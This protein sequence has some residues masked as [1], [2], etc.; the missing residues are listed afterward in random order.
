[1]TMETGIADQIIQIKESLPDGIELLAV[2]KTH[3]IESLREAYNAGQRLFGENKV[4]EM[5][6]KHSQMPEDVQWH[7]IGHVQR[8]KLHLMAPFVAVI[9]GIDSYQ[10]LAEANRQAARF[11]RRITC[12]LELHIATE[13]SKSGF[14]PEKCMQML[15]AGEW[16]NLEHIEIGGV[17]GMASYTQNREQIFAEFQQ[18]VSF[19]RTAKELFFKDSPGFHTISAGMSNDYDLAIKA[20]ANLVR[21]GTGIFGA[22]DYAK[23]EN[24]V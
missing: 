11:N 12:L 10:T 19:F 14:Q 21:I 4:Q 3:P 23:A 9:Q 2:S 5:V 17:M 24:K 8:N 16:R 22:R 15:E 1:M 6:I 13:D 18:L 20:G 7:F